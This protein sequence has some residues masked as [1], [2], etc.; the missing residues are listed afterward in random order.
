MC[1]YILTTKEEKVAKQNIAVYK[2]LRKSGRSEVM[3]FQYSLYQNNNEIQL[4]P[5]KVT[6]DSYNFCLEE[7]YHS[8]MFRSEYAKSHLFIIP[9]GAKFYPG[10]ENTR[11]TDDNENGYVSNQIIYL[12]KNTWFNRLIGLLFYGV[13]FKANNYN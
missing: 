10:C 13:E 2:E 3:H 12:G 8:R 1:L 6:Y 9:E 4:I 11:A 7:G 5:R